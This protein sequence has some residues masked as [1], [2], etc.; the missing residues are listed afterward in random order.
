MVERLASLEDWTC[1]K[2]QSTQEEDW[3]ENGGLENARH[4]P[5][6]H[7][8]SCIF[9]CHHHHHHHLYLFR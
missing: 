5:V 6:P 9:L 7:F 2:R 8:Q 4:S 3:N 1:L